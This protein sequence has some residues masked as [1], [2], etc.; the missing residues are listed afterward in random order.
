V[1]VPTSAVASLA[2]RRE[3]RCVPRPATDRPFNRLRWASVRLIAAITEDGYGVDEDLRPG[4]GLTPGEWRTLVGT[5]YKQ[6]R[7]DRCDSYLVLPAVRPPL[8]RVA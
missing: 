7:V 8:E 5:L 2:H 6:R 1:Q 4:L 3:S